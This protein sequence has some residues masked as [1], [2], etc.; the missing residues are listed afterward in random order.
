M[1]GA[2]S[3]WLPCQPKSVAVARGLLREVLA[4]TAIGDERLEV[5]ELVLSELV[6]NAVLH[7]RVPGRLIQVQVTPVGDQLRI[8]VHDASDE[9]P[10]IRAAA[11][12]DVSGRGLHLVASLAEAWGCCPRMGGGKFVWAL[13][14]PGEGDS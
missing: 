1:S 3:R 13:V 8:E 2:R 7:A 5:G 4:G 11:D 10:A 14:G 9:R 12:G 6:T